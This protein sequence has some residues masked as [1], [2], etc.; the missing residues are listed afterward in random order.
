MN[1]KISYTSSDWE[2]PADAAKNILDQEGFTDYNNAS[3][4]K[5]ASQLDSNSCYIKCFIEMEDDMSLQQSLEKLAEFGAA[6]CYSHAGNIY[7]KH[8]QAFTG[9][10]KVNLSESDIEDSP[11]VSSAINEIVNDYSIGY[12]GDANIPA[13][14]S[15]NNDIGSFSR[16]KFGTH[17]LREMGGG[18]GTQIQYMDLTSAV[19]IGEQ[20]IRRTH[21]NLDNAN[22]SPLQIISSSLSLKHQ[23]WLDLET[24]YRQSFSDE[25][26]SNKLFEISRF[27]RN[28]DRD[29]IETISYEV[30]E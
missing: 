17:S 23:E 12:D 10:V 7:Y 15:A 25:G 20:L 29:L 9:G 24:Y 27:I 18:E 11:I 22:V 13:T 1:T 21:K 28:F 8:W 16:V 14:D 30:E 6:D 5:S 4:L 19:Y 3:F 2:T 26:W